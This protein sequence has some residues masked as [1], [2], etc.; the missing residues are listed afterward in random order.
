MKAAVIVLATLS[1][2][3]ADVA[4]ASE[5]LSDVD[6][7]KANRCRGLAA[8]LGVGDT[9]SLDAL[10][11]S[12]GRTRAEPIAERAQDEFARGKR[13]AS[14]TDN[15]DRSNAELSGPCMALMSGGKDAATAR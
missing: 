9:A 11:K 10:I 1:L 3:A 4:V 15:K 12:E 7:L 6:F 13:E 14:K 5:H 8:G 2:A